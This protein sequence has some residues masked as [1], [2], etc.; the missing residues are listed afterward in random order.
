MGSLQLTYQPKLKTI[1]S[2]EAKVVQ[3]WLSVDPLAEKYPNVSPYV[4]CF[5]DPI[6][7][8]DPDGRDGI[9]VI[10]DKNKT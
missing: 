2:H 5:N 4:Y 9:R 3:L 8:I 1:H 6:N 7:V 10:D